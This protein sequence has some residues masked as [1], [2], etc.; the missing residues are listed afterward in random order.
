MEESNKLITEV[1]TL[2][3]QLKLEQH[4]NRQMESILGL[5]K[6]IMQPREAQRK[7]NEAVKTRE[8]IH[9]EY[10][11]ELAVYSRNISIYCIRTDEMKLFSDQRG[12]NSQSER[13]KYSTNK[14]IVRG[15]TQI[16]GFTTKKGISW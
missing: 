16:Q 13:R 7:L 4:R 11:A 2:R 10:E 14:S 12:S 1:N 5:T 15:K 6:K 8:D 3:N 9:K